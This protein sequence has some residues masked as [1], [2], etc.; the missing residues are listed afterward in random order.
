[1]SYSN[2]RW[3]AGSAF[4]CAVLIYIY[5][6]A[7][8]TPLLDPDEGLHAAISQQMVLSGDYVTPRF[9]DKPFLDKPILYFAAQAVSL[10]MFGMHE[11][12]VRLPGLMFALFGA[13]TTALLARRLYDRE[14]GWLALLVGL[15]LII[16]ASLAQA[17]AHD[18][19][20]VPWTNLLLVCLWESDRDISW[21]RRAAFTLGAA[22]CVALAVLTKGLI[23]IAIIAAGCAV[24]IVALR[25]FTLASIV[26]GV[27][28]FAVGILLASPWFI[29]MELQ[30]PGYLHYYFIERHLQGFATNTQPHGHA[31][32]YFHIVLMLGGTLPW[33]IYLFPA[34]GQ[35]LID[36][37]HPD[38]AADNRATVFVW[39]WLVGGMAFLSV[40]N[41]KLI[42]YSLPLYPAVAILVAHAWKQFLVR[43]MAP[44]LSRAFGWLFMLF[45]GV[46]CLVPLGLLIGF[47]HY[48]SL[49]SS[50]FAYL[51]AALG[52][53]TM[54]AALVL[55]LR[56]RPTAAVA[57]G[58]KF[59]RCYLL[60]L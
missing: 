41:S 16:P 13:L 14:T 31:R 46:G 20:L 5:P 1:M 53:A 36:R 55:F 43:E 4:V 57:I 24:F 2:Q 59:S 47:D 32:W 56:G 34:L 28:S 51:V 25:K 38:R 26:P 8:P 29:A 22:I 23:G 58:C 10:R 21:R 42:T 12:A 40:A 7:L 44:G 60:P 33:C 45:C 6:L 9:L 37:K 30:V 39:C 50:S 15:T 19:A 3:I 54:I 48:N 52:T 17:A 18:V 27:V 35:S 11:A 49:H